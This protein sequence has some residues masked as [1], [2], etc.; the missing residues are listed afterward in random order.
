MIVYFE[1]SALVKLYAQEAGSEDAAEAATKATLPVTSILTY[2]EVRSA[3]AAK[4][5]GGSLIPRGY[6]H[7]R[8]SRQHYEGALRA[9]ENGW[10]DL[11]KLPVDEGLAQS[12]GRLAELHALASLDAIHLAS[13]VGLSQ[14]AG[15]SV[16]FTSWDD[17]LRRA[18]AVEGL[19]IHPE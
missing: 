2:V 4:W 11:A 8:R 3:L 1:T 6:S 13:A 19:E 15:D 12:A 10:A 5:R 17:R 9:F 18:A 16:G 7:P 14:R